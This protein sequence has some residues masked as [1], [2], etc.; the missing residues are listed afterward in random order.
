MIIQQKDTFNTGKT[1]RQE[2]D[3]ETSALS[4]RQDKRWLPLKCYQSDV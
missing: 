4:D 3:F 1:P 2:I